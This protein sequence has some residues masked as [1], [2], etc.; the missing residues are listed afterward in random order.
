MLYRCKQND[1]LDAICKKN[2]GTEHGTTEGVLSANP[3][4]A[5]KGTHLPLGLLIHLPSVEEPITPVQKTI[6]LWD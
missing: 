5:D 3:G 4:L 2:Y 1:V 6:Q